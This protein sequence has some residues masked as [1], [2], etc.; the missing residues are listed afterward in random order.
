M[1]EEFV[2]ETGADKSINPERVKYYYE[3]K[4]RDQHLKEA[5]DPKT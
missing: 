4:N 2:E 1:N 3:L 5:L